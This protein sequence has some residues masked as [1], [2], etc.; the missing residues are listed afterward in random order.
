MT[1]ENYQPSE[2][3]AFDQQFELIAQEQAFFDSPDTDTMRKLD[4]ARQNY[5]ESIEVFYPHFCFYALSPNLSLDNETLDEDASNCLQSMK[6]LLSVVTKRGEVTTEQAVVDVAQGL[7]VHPARIRRRLA[8]ELPFMAT[9]ELIVRAVRAG[10]IPRRRS[11]LALCAAGAYRRW[12]L[13]WMRGWGDAPRRTRRMRVRR[14]HR[15]RCW[16][17]GWTWCGRTTGRC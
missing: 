17:P 10:R 12:M 5:D 14:R 6:A 1:G 11:V 15:G 2:Q 13:P 3:E 16:P 9:E 4:V 7:E 8:E